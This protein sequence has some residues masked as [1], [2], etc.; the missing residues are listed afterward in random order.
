MNN[1]SDGKSDGIVIM[2]CKGGIIYPVDL[3][4]EQLEMLDLSIGICFQGTL[5]VIN[6]PLGEAVIL[7]KK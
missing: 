1:M 2:Y 6:K 3:N 4:K 5:N 7:N